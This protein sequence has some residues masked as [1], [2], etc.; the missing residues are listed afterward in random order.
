MPVLLRAPCEKVNDPARYVELAGA[1]RAGRRAI[2]E[3]TTHVEI[4][5]R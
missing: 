4:R 2:V 5:A 1:K 3:E